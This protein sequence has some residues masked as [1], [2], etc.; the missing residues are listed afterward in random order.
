MLRK[1]IKKSFGSSVKEHK[2]LLSI[3]KLKQ[4]VKKKKINL[5]QRQKKGFPD[6]YGRLSTIKLDPDAFINVK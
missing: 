1:F 6:T 5:K 3:E 4:K 2:G